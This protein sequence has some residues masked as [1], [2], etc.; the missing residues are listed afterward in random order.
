MMPCKSFYLALMIVIYV[1]I[2]TQDDDSDLQN[3]LESSGNRWSMEALFRPET[4]RFFSGRFL[5]TSCATSPGRQATKNTTFLRVKTLFF[6][7][8][9]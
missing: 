6:S 4:V 9:V 5:P 1:Y 7:L 3:R 8:L 2:I